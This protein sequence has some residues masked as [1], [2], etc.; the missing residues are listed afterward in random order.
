MHKGAAVISLPFYFSLSH[1]QS[2]IFWKHTCERVHSGYTHTHTHTP[3][4]G[5]VSQ[6]VCAGLEQ[7]PLRTPAALHHLM[8]KRQK[9]VIKC[10]RADMIART[11]K[12]LDC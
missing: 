9:N 5:V 3:A 10:R 4:A 6:P 11:F 12:G 8:L 2:L 7:V 1:Y